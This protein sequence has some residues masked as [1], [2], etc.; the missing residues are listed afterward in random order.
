[1][2]DGKMNRCK[3]CMNKDKRK[4]YIK[5]LAKY[6]KKQAE[7]RENNREARRAYNREWNRKDRL[8]HPEKEKARKIKREKIKQQAKVAWADPLKI[9][10]IYLERRR[11]SEETGIEHHVDH[12][13]PLISKLVCGLHVENNLRVIPAL[14]NLQ[15]HNTF[16]PD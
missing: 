10:E 5:N 3:E 9:R 11:I 4:S 8:L 13:I 15:K 12:I 7:Y 6:K 16:I 1:M 2:R 14:E